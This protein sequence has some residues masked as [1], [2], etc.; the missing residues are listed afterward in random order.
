MVI[1]NNNF[2]TEIKCKVI[3]AIIHDPTLKFVQ[4]DQKLIE[5]SSGT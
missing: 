2:F 4:C 3:Y 1:V 5:I